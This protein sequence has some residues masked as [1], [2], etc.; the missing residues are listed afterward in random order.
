LP[1]VVKKG[2]PLIF[3]QWHP[4]MA[5]VSGGIRHRGA[6]AERARG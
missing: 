4:G 2:Q 3:R 5:L 1:V 6:A